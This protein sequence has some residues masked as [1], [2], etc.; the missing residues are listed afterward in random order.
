[1]NNLVNLEQ[2]AKETKVSISTV[3]RALT[4]P[5]RVA[6]ATR[7]RV[8]KAAVR[9]GYAPNHLARSLRQGDSKTIGLIL[10]D[11]MVRFH[12]E[13]AKGVEDVAQA[14]GYSTILCNSNEDGNR[15][16]QYLELLSGFRVGGVILEPTELNVASVEA[17]VRAGIQVVEVDRISGASGVTAVLSDNIGGATSAAEHFL[18]LGHREFGL[19]LGNLAFTSSRERRDGF[20][21][22]LEKAGIQ[23]EPRRMQNCMNNPGGGYRATLELLRAASQITALFIGNAQVM[24]GTLKAV[25]ELGLRIP[26]DISVISFDDTDWAAFTD[27]ALTVVAQP[28]YELGQTAANLIFNP[29][30]RKVETPVRLPTQLIV[31]QSTAAPNKKGLSL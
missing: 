7:E 23:L 31:R 30:K 3:S 13:V 1:M 6:A 12:S 22:R 5:H 14:S 15:E 8:Q 25:R 18:H 20:L 11:I 17:L 4:Q 2:I 27:P 26:Q 29:K 28:A 24:N 9:L 10:S 19:V 21:Q 16:A